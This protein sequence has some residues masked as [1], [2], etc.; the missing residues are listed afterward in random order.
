MALHLL[1]AMAR[2]LHGAVR[3]AGGELIQP[4]PERAVDYAI[5]SPYWLDPDVLLG[6]RQPRAARPLQLAIDGA[7]WTG[8]AADVFSGGLASASGNRARPADA[9]RA[10]RPAPRRRPDDLEVLAGEDVI[11]AYAVVGTIGPGGADG[12]IEVLVHVAP[13]TGAGRGR[14]GVGRP[15]LRDLRDPLG[16]PRPRGA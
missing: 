7:D 2:R 5:H 6:R 1:V 15:A 14:A 9:R 4:D 3:V 16:V 12:A 8:P 13:A 10:R 11:D